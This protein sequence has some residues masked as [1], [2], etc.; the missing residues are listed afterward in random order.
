MAK[1]ERT[2]FEVSRASEYFDARQLSALTSTS[3]EAPT[4]NFREC[5]KGEVRGEG[6]ISRPAYVSENTSRGAHPR[7]RMAGFLGTPPRDGAR[8]GMLISSSNYGCCVHVHQRP[9]R[10]SC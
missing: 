2:T 3:L 8:R 9:G 5:P 10:R 4:A 1:L 7:F 6:V